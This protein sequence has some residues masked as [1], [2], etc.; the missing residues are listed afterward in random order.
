MTDHSPI[1]TSISYSYRMRGE[2]PGNMGLFYRDA[3]KAR[4][5][6]DAARRELPGRTFPKEQSP[7]TAR[8]G[9]AD[10]PKYR[11]P[12]HVLP[13]PHPNFAL[14]NRKLREESW[15]QK[16]RTRETG[17][18]MTRAEFMAARKDT[19]KSRSRDRERD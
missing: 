6:F 8:G 14:P 4:E 5:A 16:L 18:A 2:L 13:D 3:G 15:F 17:A 1:V 11:T 12:R 9:G 7:E 19:D 10:T